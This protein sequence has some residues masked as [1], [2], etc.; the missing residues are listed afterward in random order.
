IPYL[1]PI[2]VF[3]LGYIIFNKNA[4]RFAEIL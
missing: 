4:K 2:V 3:A 1:L